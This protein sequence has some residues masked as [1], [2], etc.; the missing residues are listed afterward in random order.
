MKFTC[1]FLL[2]GLPHSSSSIVR[3]HISWACQATT[4]T[5]SVSEVLY[6]ASDFF[7]MTV[8]VPL[9][10][11]DIHH[12]SGGP[13]DQFQCHA[14]APREFPELQVSSTAC[15]ATLIFHTVTPVRAIHTTS[16]RGAASDQAFGAT[17]CSTTD[18]HC[19]MRESACVLV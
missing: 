15:L 8:M 17:C 5:T 16:V 13:R 6:A 12:R 14:D 19:G 1:A 10:L 7:L 3:T 2:L 4:R 9:A 11:D 18:V